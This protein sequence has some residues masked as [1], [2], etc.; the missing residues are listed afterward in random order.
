[1]FFVVSLSLE[2][3]VASLDAGIFE[4]LKISLLANEHQ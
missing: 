2:H 3:W 1:M 4:K